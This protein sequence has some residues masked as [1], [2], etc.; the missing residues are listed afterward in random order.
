MKIEHYSRVEH[1]ER[2]AEMRR[3]NRVTRITSGRWSIARRSHHEHTEMEDHYQLYIDGEM[4][5]SGLGLYGLKLLVSKLRAMR[6]A[7]VL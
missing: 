3:R 1:I 4:D 2:W 6:F 5:D 7:G